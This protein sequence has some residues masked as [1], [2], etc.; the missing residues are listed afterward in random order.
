[1]S[2]LTGNISPKGAVTGVLQAVYG[3]D[4]VSVSHEWEGTTLKV[5]SASG[6]SSADLKGEAGNPGVYVGETEPTDPNVTVWVNP[7]GSEYTTIKDIADRMC[8]AFTESGAAVSCEP[9]EGYPLEVVSQIE[10]VQSGTG[11]P[12][13]NNIRPISGHS[14][15]KLTRAGKNILNVPE[16]LAFTKYMNL[17]CYIPA[18]TYKLTWESATSDKDAE[19]PLILFESENNSCKFVTENKEAIITLREDIKVVH[20][21][22]TVLGW[23]ASEGVSATITKLMLSVNGGEYEPYRGE[24]FEIDLGQTVYGGTLNWNTGVL[25]VDSAMYTFTGQETLRQFNDK[26]YNGEICKNAQ[27]STGQGL[28]IGRSSHVPAISE[29][30]SRLHAGMVLHASINAGIQ[31]NGLTTYWGLAEATVDAMKA[32]LAEQYAAGTPVQITYKL[33]NPITIQLQPQEILALSG[34]NTLYSDTGD[35]EVAGRANPAAIIN[36]LLDRLAAIEAAVVNNA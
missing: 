18:G 29:G 6:T 3:K 20:F 7:N 17:N 21:Y 11:D 1:M 10:P 23:N 13:P 24:T 2:E 9:V 33:L 32:Y 30:D 28:V 34:V 12:S 31:F 26:V 36:N 19:T 4:G 14:A 15:V 5:T 16:T 27:S 22:S 35:T 25:T 8:P